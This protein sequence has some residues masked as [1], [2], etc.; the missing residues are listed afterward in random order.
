MAVTAGTTPPTELEPSRPASRRVPALD[1]LR[2]FALI[3]M[4]LWHAEVTWVQGGFVRMTIF[5][6]LSGYLA[7]GSWH[8]IREGTGGH[9]GFATFWWRRARRLLPV[10]YLGVAIAIGVTVATGSDDM[11]DRLGGDVLSVLLYVSNLRFWLSGQGYGELFTEPSLLQHYWTL[12]IE[13]QAFALVPLLLAGVAAVAGRSHLRRQA[14]LI[15]ALAAVGVAL[16]ALVHHDADAVWY[17]SPIRIGEFCGGVALAL[18][19][20]GGSGRW[21]D[22][23]LA[24]VGTAS[25]AVIVAAVVLLPRDA[26]WLY[27]GGMGLFL[28]PTLGLLAAASRSLGSAARLLSWRPLVALGRWTFSVYV[29]HWPLFFV[30]DQVRTGL[31]GWELATL[32]LAAAIGIGAVLH[33][34]I[35]RP[36]MAAARVDDVATGLAGAARRRSAIDRVARAWVPAAWWRTRPAAIALGG[37]AVALTA[38]GWLPA[39][40]DPYEWD[41]VEHES[42]EQAEMRMFDPDDGRIPLA[43]FGG[44]TAVLLDLGGDAWM[45]SSDDLA[46]RPGGTRLACGLVRQGERI[47]GWDP[48]TWEPVTGR[49]D[50]ECTAWPDV[51]PYV[52]QLGGAEVALLVVGTWDTLDVELAGVGRTHVGRPEYDRIVLDELS[53]ALDGFRTA[54]VRQLQLATTPV[55][56]RGETGR[57]RELRGLGDDHP[58]RVAAF[59]A[60]LHRFADAHDDVV[61]IDYGGYVD[62]MDEDLKA[63]LLPDGVHPTDEAAQLLWT[64][65]LGPAIVAAADD[66]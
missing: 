29:I 15:G 66:S 47:L 65:F 16:P 57:A 1:G 27:R 25:F 49:S 48:Q 43:I 58:E 46:T 38:A 44:S 59:N 61:V 42:V 56:G 30:L 55:V 14:V 13:E 35:E 64:D 34:L 3:G 36:L 32:R 17:S 7:A 22:R 62:R 8:R 23:R 9:G 40:D 60:L 37:S 51:W 12:S 4:L 52:A 63:E 18:A 5:F 39:G 53:L 11:R 50:D 24:F 21:S 20:T 10:S 2:A 54:G 28:V 31:G 41:R 19:M 26:D 6:A 33:V 45:R